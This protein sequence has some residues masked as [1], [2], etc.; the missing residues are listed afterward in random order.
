MAATSLVAAAA[1]G[2][3]MC[4]AADQSR[5]WVLVD[6]ADGS[7]AKLGQEYRMRAGWGGGKG[8]LHAKALHI[9]AY[10]KLT[11]G[12][13]NDPIN[14]Q[15][16]R[17]LFASIRIQLANGQILAE[18]IEGRQIL[19]DHYFRTGG[20]A[21]LVHRTHFGI[22][23]GPYPDV[24]DRE[25]IEEDAGAGTAVVPISLTIH[26]S[27]PLASGMALIRDLVPVALLEGDGDTGVT[28]QIRDEIPGAPAGVTLEGIYS[29][30][31]GTRAGIDV[32]AEVVD[33]P[34]A[35]S[36]GWSRIVQWAHPDTSGT[37]RGLP[38]KSRVIY[39]A[40]TGT[41]SAIA[42][43]DALTVESGGI[44]MMKALKAEDAAMQTRLEA[45]SRPFGAERLNKA[46]LAA[47]IEDD[48]GLHA[49]FLVPPRDRR[50]APVA[51]VSFSFTRSTQQTS[52]YLA[53]VVEPMTPERAARTQA[54]LEADGCGCPSGGVP[55]VEAGA[56]VADPYEP[57]FM[58][59][60]G[61][62]LLR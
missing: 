28:M 62:S 34:A 56:A 61:L 19:L 30:A 29:N 23:G 7:R 11:V 38:D 14:A 57:V 50:A 26:F 53:R 8:V 16:L 41:P 43:H 2:R 27:D 20:A 46:S 40:L 12:A 36:K 59:R 3:R 48:D 15:T 60:K 1:L 17:G 54:V 10:A 21:N 37:L 6:R 13:A 49:L 42:D 32:W 33:L 35:V 31:A 58:P 39:C 4:R 52:Q 24:T 45:W 18:N 44:I 9:S 5:R 51:P 47:P 55:L 25:A 22:E